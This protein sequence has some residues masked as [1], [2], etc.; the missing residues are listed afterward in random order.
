M[1]EV[2]K[3]E[4]EEIISANRHNE[5]KSVLKQIAFY[6]SSEKNEKKDKE[7][8]DEI[9]KQSQNIEHFFKS[10]ELNQNSKELVSSSSFNKMREDILASNERLVKTI[11][12]RLLPD[13]FDLIRNGNDRAQSVKVNYKEASKIKTHNN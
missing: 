5:L 10:I 13:T 11:E 9:R 8:V 4:A 6:L 12:N 3:D 7:V 2:T 1:R